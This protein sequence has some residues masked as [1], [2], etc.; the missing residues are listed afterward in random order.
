M[1]RQRRSSRPR[2]SSPQ[3]KS[4]SL[5]RRRSARGN[6]SISRSRSMSPVRASN[7]MRL[8]RLS[9]DSGE[10]NR[11]GS[12]QPLLSSRPGA[13]SVSPYQSSTFTT[14]AVSRSPSTVRFASPEQSP[15]LSNGLVEETANG[16]LHFPDLQASLQSFDLSTM[17]RSYRE[18]TSQRRSLSSSHRVWEEVHE[19][20]RGLLTTPKAVQ[21]L[22][23]GAT[24][25]E[26]DEVLARRSISPGP[27][28]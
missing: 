2:T 15:S 18:D 4:Q 9:L 13:R 21:R 5:V 23:Y 8:A 24:N 14:P 25:S 12:P 19:R 16:D 22:V 27:P 28:L 26:V 10:Q 6:R 1:K 11:A 7:S 17:R 20:V 3:R